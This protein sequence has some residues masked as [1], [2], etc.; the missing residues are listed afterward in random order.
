MFRV[1]GRGCALIF[2]LVVFALP[3][4][5]SAQVVPPSTQ[6]TLYQYYTNINL[7]NYQAAYAMWQ[8]PPQTLTQ[9]Q[10]GFAQT[11]RIEPFFNAL[12]SSQP[13]MN[14]G[15]VRAVLLGYQATGTVQTYAG[16]FTLVLSGANWKISGSNFVLVAEGQAPDAATI[17]TLLA[18]YCNTNPSG[19]PVSTLPASEASTALLAYYDL[20][21]QKQYQS[22]YNMW[23]SPAPGPQPNGSPSQ[24]YRPPLTSFQSGYSTT[25]YIY[26]YLGP[27]NFGGASAGHAYLD[28]FQ[29][30]V[31]VGQHTDGTFYAYYGCYVMG[32]HP[33]G[34]F[35]IV[36]GRFFL[37]ANQ[38]PVGADILQHLN[39]DC[40]TLNI[41]M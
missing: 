13:A 34:T 27:Y 33:D 29:P 5:A 38:A 26:A 20:I 12:E 32:H 19:T 2:A 3:G 7:G 4:V 16:C 28:G 1:I 37:F 30:A 11:I 6:A 31:L 21:N 8:N 10:N 18:Q 22:A 35:G 23:L 41:P 14:S 36:N 39:V 40:T 9:F 17:S 15:T 24:D 25:A